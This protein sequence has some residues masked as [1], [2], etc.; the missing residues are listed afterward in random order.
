MNETATPDTFAYLILGLVV[1]S[2]IFLAFLGSMVVRQRNLQK[3]IQ[4][5]EQLGDEH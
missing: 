2:G 1:A 5:L 4:L 3:D